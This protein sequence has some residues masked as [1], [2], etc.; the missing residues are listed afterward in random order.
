[1]RYGFTVI[2]CSLVALA[3]SGCNRA[4][5]VLAVYTDGKITRG[6]FLNW[7]EMNHYKAESV[8]KNKKQFMDKLKRMAVD[9]IAALEAR[10]HGFDR[11]EHFKVIAD[12]SS[13]QQLMKHLYKREITEGATF[14]EPVVRISHIYLRVR[15]FKVE[16]NKKVKLTRNEM[17]LELKK[18]LSRARSILDKLK[19]GEKFSDLAKKYSQDFSRKKGGDIG[20][21]I[22]DMLPPEYSRVVFTL[23]E[24]DYA[25]E[26][27]TVYSDK[28]APLPNGVYIVM[29]TDKAELTEDNIEDVIENTVEAQRLKN[30]LL[31]RKS[32]QYVR[33][34]MN[35]DD[36]KVQIEKAVSA[37]PGQV[38]FK[39]G[40][41]VY[42]VNDLNK[43]I[44]LFTSRFRRGSG[45]VPR[46]TDQQKMSLA[47][48]ILR[49]ELLKREAL[50]K[51]IDKD[52]EFLKNA[53]M[54]TEF[55]LA[56]EYMKSMH[57]DAVKVTESEMRAEYEKNRE[58]RYY[59]M[60]TKGNRRE[61]EI[62]P[63]QRVKERIRRILESSKRNMLIEQW[64]TDILRQYKFT[65]NE[66]ELD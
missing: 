15:D 42:T 12:M 27:I 48:N 37:D 36:V 63:F 39:I 46:V 41:T 6:E 19:S 66:S 34:L 14:S 29:V 55:L 54:R 7:M 59:R 40:E 60:I 57:A 2:I 11:S 64:K 53:A 3:L 22:F 26:P 33:N 10:K 16:K 65:I 1:M 9:R 61:K 17:D 21:R 18:T 49:F 62:E 35:R 28:P 25:P 31:R 23:N 56:R 47:Q 13:E 52:P 30:R 45:P 8:T 51:G 38:L 4:D 58:K 44:Q 24:D 43:R 50:R 32:Q 20:Y 5:E